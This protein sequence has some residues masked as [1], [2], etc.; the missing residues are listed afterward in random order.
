MDLKDV[1]RMSPSAQKQILAK[2]KV[3]MEEEKRSKYGNRQEWRGDIRFAS[4]KEARRYDELMVLLNAG[5]IEDL[6]LQPQYTLQEAY[7]LPNGKRVQAIR[8]VADYSYRRGGELIVE[9]VK[10]EATKTRVYQIK[11]KLLL[12]K[13][14]I[15]IREI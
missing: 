4:K 10:S 7:T 14:G 2:L 8:Y 13:F 1:A 15:A 3:Q 5:E 6:K 12:D 9:D 11:R